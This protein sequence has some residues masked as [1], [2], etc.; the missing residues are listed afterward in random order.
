MVETE[1][2]MNAIEPEIV[3]DI[4]AS[5]LAFVEPLEHGLVRFWL[6]AEENGERIVKAKIVMALEAGLEANALA[7]ANLIAARRK[8]TPLRVI[9]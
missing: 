6:Y 1:G 2:H 7:A 3:P 8:I 9:S 4:Y 5:G